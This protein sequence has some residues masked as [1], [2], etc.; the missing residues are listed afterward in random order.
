MC[1]KY[2]VDEEVAMA[3][4]ICL[5]CESESSVMDVRLCIVEHVQ[6]K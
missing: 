4:W 5:Y 1:R 2:A 3:L 6:V